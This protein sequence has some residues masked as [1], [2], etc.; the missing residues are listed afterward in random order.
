MT[1]AWSNTVAP[2]L[3]ENVIGH[4]LRFGTTLSVRGAKNLAPFAYGTS[5]LPPSIPLFGT[6]LLVAILRLVRER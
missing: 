2:E 1:H 6:F 5:I 4:I 3:R